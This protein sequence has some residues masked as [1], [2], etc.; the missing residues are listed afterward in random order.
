MTNDVATAAYLPK[1]LRCLCYYGLLCA[2]LDDR[3]H[4]RKG[5]AKSLENACYE[6][7]FG[8]ESKDLEKG[9]KPSKVKYG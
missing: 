6:A 2:A 9:K 5:V 7:T 3:D 8:E 4:I 1:P